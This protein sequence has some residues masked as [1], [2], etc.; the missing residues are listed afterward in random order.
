MNGEAALRQAGKRAM[1]NNTVF[2]KSSLSFPGYQK[3]ADEK[4]KLLRLGKAH[5]ALLKEGLGGGGT[6][7]G[8]TATF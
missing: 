4:A 2:H 5:T 8:G 1:M 7:R 6:G 3:A